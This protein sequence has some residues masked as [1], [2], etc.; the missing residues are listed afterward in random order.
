M[1]WLRNFMGF[2][3]SLGFVVVVNTCC[4]WE[5]TK[6]VLEI[7]WNEEITNVEKTLEGTQRFKVTCLLLEY[8]FHSY[9]RSGFIP[10]IGHWISRLP[11][12]QL[13]EKEKIN[14]MGI[15]IFMTCSL[16]FKD[17][18]EHAC[19]SQQS[20]SDLSNVYSMSCINLV[21][22]SCCLFSSLTSAA[23]AE[24]KYNTT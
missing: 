22:P 1:S 3:S 14:T 13:C 12:V 7:I 4:I 6:C 23:R 9:Q 19:F 20:K 2:T 10:Y 15:I 18:Y 16:Y 5:N 21:P 11:F 24:E 8:L 17:A